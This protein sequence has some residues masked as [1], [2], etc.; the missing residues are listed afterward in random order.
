MTATTGALGWFHP[1]A[2]LM[3][4]LSIAWRGTA[5]ETVGHALLFVPSKSAARRPLPPHRTETKKTVRNM[6]NTLALG[7]LSLS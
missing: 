7:Y 4:L 2:V 6:L 1:M 3:G 5:K